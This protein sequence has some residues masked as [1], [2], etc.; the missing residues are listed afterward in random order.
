MIGWKSLLI[1]RDWREGREGLGSELV[2]CPR[3]HFARL[4]YENKA[5]DANQREKSC[6]DESGL[7][8]S[9]TASLAE[10]LA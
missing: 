1:F 7:L 2:K 5:V 4:I 9:L 8:L 10:V 6:E 3:V